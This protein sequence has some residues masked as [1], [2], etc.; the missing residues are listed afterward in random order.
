[1]G[2]FT[3]L[4]IDFDLEIVEDFVSHYGIMCET[5]EPLIIGLGKKEYYENN[6]GE[7]F[8]IFHNLKSA[9]GFLK[10]EPIIKLSTLCEDVA[11]EARILEGPATDEF[12]D[13]LLLVSDQFAKYKDDIEED[14]EYFSMLNP[15]II[16]VPI[17]LQRH[18]D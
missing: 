1:M 6:I 16:K 10:L 8:R 5:M 17:H 15:L 4:E 9:A 12:I 2:L 7:L 14:A 11:E 3:Q 18:D 13:W